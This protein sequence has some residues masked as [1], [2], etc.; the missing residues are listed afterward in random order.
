MS[1]VT[2]IRDYVEFLNNL[3]QSF[4]SSIPISEFLQG[5]GIYLYKTLQLIGIYVLTFQWIH[6]F[7]LL[8]IKVPQLSTLVLQE[9]FFLNDSSNLIFN[10]LDFQS[11]RQNSFLLGWFN[12]LFFS[13]PIS[14]IHIIAIRRLY[15]KGIPAGFFSIFGYIAGQLFFT[16]CVIFG[17]RSI[18]NSWFII[19]PLNY[20]LGIILIF[21]LVYEMTQ[22]TL[23]QI[24]SWTEKKYINYFFTS[25]I[26]AW[27][28]QSS[29]FQYLGNL[30]LGANVS[31]LETTLITS[32]FHTFLEHSLYI[33]GL[34][35]GS[36]FFTIVWGLIF[37]QIKNFFVIYTP[38]FLSKFIQTVN[39]GSFILAIA[40]SLT[41]L[42]FYGLDYLVTAPLGFVSQD[43]VFKNTLFDQYNIKDSVLGLGRSSHFSSLDLD[44]TP[45]DRGRYL[46]FPES[47][48]P[49]SFED[50][51]YRGEVRW[52][53][54]YDNVSNVK[55]RR[56]GFSLG[57]YLKNQQVKN[58]DSVKKLPG[59][60]PIISKITTDANQPIQL[61]ENNNV[62]FSNW[63]SLDTSSPDDLEEIFVEAQ[64][65]SFPLDFI[66]TESVEPGFID[67]KIKSKYYSNPVYRN[68]LALDID[69]LLNRQPK[70]FFLT[71][72][73]ELDLYTKRR[74]LTNYFNSMRDYSRLPYTV[75]FENF[76]EGSKSFSNKVYNQQFKGTLRSLSRLFALTSDLDSTDNINELVLKYDQ[77]LYIFPNKEKLS[78]YHEELELNPKQALP[79]LQDMVSAPLY[80]GWDENLRQFIIT[81]RFLARNKSGIQVKLD[82]KPLTKDSFKQKTKNSDKRL[83]GSQATYQIRF[84]AWPLKENSLNPGRLQSKIPFTALFTPKNE[85]GTGGNPAFESLSKLPANW[86]TRNRKSA[87]GVGK[88]YENIFDYLA[89][90]RGGFI[91][92][93]NQN[94]EFKLVK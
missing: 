35:L 69:L 68:L 48:L 53:N 52:T 58:T 42:P 85:F 14:I 3:T 36:V 2:I 5:T 23:K 9:K 33:F 81:N 93:G 49:F 12:S 39:T 41:S 25:F 46:L 61:V 31:L 4:N 15:I 30:S 17:V 16:S 62:R 86:E 13:F 57:N 77:P 38:L 18:I 54:R 21:K 20:L 78:F 64:D 67:L 72:D 74:M 40:L 75:E 84:T 71:K 65:T 37:L 45:F 83:F 26:L 34:L 87:T 55:Y 47:T 1:I 63:Y 51:N 29:M 88:T 11:I 22:E 59:N 66:R 70:K 92:P 28:E 6:D 90:Q 82:H 73:Q 27:C 10:F 94:L 91:W 19:E 76:F 43:K 89:P 8:P 50:L 7:T 56:A 60:L 80:A 32:T 79:F 24:P 44:L